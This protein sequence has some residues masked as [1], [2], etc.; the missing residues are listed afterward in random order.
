MKTLLAALAALV[1]STS[2][3]AGTLTVH[4]GP[5]AV[6]T[7]GTNPTSIPP[8]DPLEYEVEWITKGGFESNIGIT[9]GLLFGAR[10]RMEHLYVGFGGGLVISANGS[11]PG[12][13]TSFGVNAAHFN[14]EI[15]QALGFDFEANQV[16]SPYAIRLGL[17]FDIGRG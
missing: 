8:I 5:P 15:K 16:I 9:P 12:C 6:G 10:S 13:Y 3:A 14:A 11:G 2:A 17:T 7:G 1:L 4:I